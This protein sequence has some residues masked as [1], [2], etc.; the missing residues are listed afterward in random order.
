[1]VRHSILPLFAV[2]LLLVGCNEK[3]T[4][5]EVTVQ[6]PTGPLF[7]LLTPQATNVSFEN[8]L[9]DDPVRNVLVY[10][11][12][13]NGSGVAVGDV[14]N[15]GLQDI[16]F[17]A[18]M[19]P[20]A[21]YINQG[22]LKFTE[23]AREAGVGGKR[24]WTTGVTMADVNADGH[25][26]IYVCRSGNLPEDHRANLLFINDGTGKFTEQGESFGLNDKSYSTQAS[27]FDYDKDGDLDMY[28]VNHSI[29]RNQ[30]VDFY[31]MVKARDPFAGD[32]LYR[33]DNGHFTDVSAA[34]GII[35]N[36][37][38]YGLGIAVSD[39]N[40]DD[41]PDIYV[42]NDYL[43][44]DYLYYNNGDGTFTESLAG[45]TKHS[46]NFSM[47]TD[48]ADFNNDGMADIMVVDMAAEDNFRSK[49]NMSGMSQERFWRA[50]DNG[51]HY[52]YMINTLQMNNGNGTFSEVSQLAGMSNTDWS[53][54]PLWA[55]FDNDGYKDLLVTNGLRKEARNNDFIKLKKK[56]L[57]EMEQN[58]E[59]RNK[60]LQ[61]ILSM[62]PSEKIS[63]YI[64]KNEGNMTFTS[65]QEEWGLSEKTFSNGAAYA[66]LDNDGDLDLV[67][68]NID[69]NAFIYRNN[70]VDFKAGNYL[71]LQLKGTAGN[72]MAIGTKLK[73]TA[74][75]QDQYQELYLTRGYQSSVENRVHFGLN[76]AA[77]VDRLEITWPD[78]Q[79]QTLENLVA[80][81]LLTVE[82]AP[83][84]AVATPGSSSTLFGDYSAQL[85]L[86]ISHQENEFDDFEKEILLP[87]K[88]SAFGPG[89]AVADAN[90]DGLD[91]F[92]LGGAKGFSGQLMVQKAAGGFEKLRGPWEKDQNS[93][94]LGAAFFDADG[95]GDHDLYVV[96]GGNEFSKTDPAL[97]DRLYINDGSGQF[98][99]S[100]TALPEM[101]TSGGCVSPGDYDG[102]G[103]LDLFVGGRV[104]PGEY[105]FAPQSYLL[106]NEG[107]KFTDVTEA[108]APELANAGLITSA[109]WTD[110]NGD[111]SL[112]LLVAG[113]WTPLMVFS[114]NQ[115]QFALQSLENTEGWWFGLTAGD[116]DGDGDQDYI[117]GNLGLNYKYQAS[118]EEPFSIYC[119]DFDKN[120][121][122]DIVLGYYN[123]GECYPVRGRQCTSEQMPFITEKFPDYES[124]ASSNLLDIYEENLDAALHYKAKIFASV[125]IRNNGNGDFD[126]EPLPS[127]A[128]VSSINSL[129]PADYNGDGHLDVLVAG[130]LYVSEVETPRNDASIGLL[131]QGDGTGQFTP[132]PHHQSGFMADGDVRALA[133]IK[134]ADGKTGVLIARNN[135]KVGLMVLRSTGKVGLASER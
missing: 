111:G 78:G 27:F 92:Y 70:A 106:E 71:D 7:T 14:N 76:D 112:D 113:E 96:S 86:N 105:P 94:D 101:L 32:K 39:L 30:G 48:I 49:T 17:T 130:N 26:D 95:D 114:N 43:E 99:K 73:I 10:E 69:S 11:Y 123:N 75:G 89:L 110:H 133:P 6:E 118:L 103:D 61:E 3:A 66:D 9:T 35:G 44:H 53:W 59:L 93:E 120:G 87:H 55:D 65:M 2:V 18:N 50:V 36:S 64:Y 45:A 115:G 85:A 97:Q 47:G 56:K 116:F 127:E 124:F 37:I 40:G 109:I 15:D 4:K 90:N 22:D 63:N 1:M 117:A 12:F 21:L 81:Q 80:N 34:A 119:D 28:L 54:A 57:A 8:R 79:T 102:D 16:Y 125:F 62:M 91:D 58:P 52:Q 60:Y 19:A 5:E 83:T 29:Q 84:S 24:G 122:Y 132:V 42:C 104:I 51:F 46:S 135:D 68:C 121:T 67:I 20:N 31:E 107:G 33:N 23:T 98:T 82:Y 126:I 38:G 108:N 74:N 131:L 72:P 13:H 128:Q 134:V 77:T 100:T 88:M 129:V 25:L 41:W